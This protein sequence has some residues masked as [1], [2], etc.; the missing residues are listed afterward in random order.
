MSN[1]HFPSPSSPSNLIAWNVLIIIH[2]LQ[3]AVQMSV[4]QLAGYWGSTSRL[5]GCTGCFLWKEPS[6]L[7][8]F[9]LHETMRSGKSL[10]VRLFISLLLYLLLNSFKNLSS[11][12][13]RYLG[14]QLEGLSRGHLFCCLTEFPTIAFASISIRSSSL[15]E[16]VYYFLLQSVA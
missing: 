7:N 15:S 6:S 11:G 9:S 2:W 13:K 12:A 10:W 14:D 1:L 4:S 16:K 5:P 8:F 3:G